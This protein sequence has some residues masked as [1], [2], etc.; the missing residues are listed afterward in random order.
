MQTY[1]QIVKE[2][3]LRSLFAGNL[4]CCMRVL[5]FGGIV[6]VSYG[7]ILKLLPADNELD[8][9]EPVWRSIAGAGA[10]SLATVCT[11]PL[12]LVRARLAVQNASNSSSKWAEPLGI[13][14]TFSSI[15]RNEGGYAALYRGIGPTLCAVAPFVALQ[16]ATYDTMK[17]AAFEQGIEPTV[18]LFLCCG[19]F[20]GATAQTMIHPLDLVRRR[21]QVDI[22]STS[23][24]RA[25]NGASRQIGRTKLLSVLRST[26]FV[27]MFGGLTPALLKIMPAA[28][29]SLIV[30]DAILG[31]L[32]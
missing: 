13:L 27:G 4:A 24:N 17:M 28:S 10:A 16:Q 22:T 26:G 8:A 19:A 29:I 14:G 18:P 9:M 3:G 5:P 25:S 12:D 30:R 21:M 32:K 31:R 15:V 2:G 7:R 6:C 20:A 1:R 11:Y 23:A